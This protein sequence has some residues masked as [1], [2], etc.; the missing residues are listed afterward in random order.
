MPWDPMASQGDVDVLDLMEEAVSAQGHVHT[1][2]GQ[3]E[4][5]RHDDANEAKHPVTKVSLL[6]RTTK[7]TACGATPSL[8]IDRAVA[9]SE[10]PCLNRVL[11]RRVGRGYRL[12]SAFFKVPDRS[13]GCGTIMWMTP[14]GGL[15]TAALR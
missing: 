7:T 5:L 10:W 4:G 14:G 15:R 12:T 13:Y 11:G 2:T 9:Q 8:A 3:A 1:G 6:L